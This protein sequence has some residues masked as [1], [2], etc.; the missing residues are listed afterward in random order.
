MVFAHPACCNSKRRPRDTT[1]SRM[2]RIRGHIC[3]GER[4]RCTISS[5]SRSSPNIHA[6]EPTSN[7]SSIRC[8]SMLCISLCQR[9]RPTSPLPLR[10][11]LTMKMMKGQPPLMSHTELQGAPAWAMMGSFRPLRAGMGV[12]HRRQRYVSLRQITAPDRDVSRIPCPCIM[13]C[14]LCSGSG[15]TWN[16]Q[17]IAETMI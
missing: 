1:W 9:M 4:V 13:N 14:L 5:S 17:R 15:S 6:P 7:T 3:H 2:L 16:P 10:M 8:S 11:T 12:L